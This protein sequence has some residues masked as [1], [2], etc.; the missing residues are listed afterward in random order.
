M[1]QPAPAYHVAEDGSKCKAGQTVVKEDGVT[2]KADT[3]SDGESR[4]DVRDE[5]SHSRKR[6]LR[7][8][9]EA[10]IAAVVGATV[11]LVGLWFGWL[12]LC[13]RAVGL[14]MIGVAALVAVL[15]E[16][17]SSVRRK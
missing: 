10:V 17:G 4:Q 8:V 16:L 11:V 5:R 2:S 15:L 6:A 1:E 14:T 3:Q 7:I 13:A 9:G 12:P